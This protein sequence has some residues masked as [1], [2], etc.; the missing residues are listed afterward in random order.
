MVYS[1]DADV[2]DYERP[3]DIF[4]IDFVVEQMPY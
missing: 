4:G 1:T 2:Q 3:G